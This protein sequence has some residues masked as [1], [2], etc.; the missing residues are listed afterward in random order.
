M[1]IIIRLI[2]ALIG[3]FFLASTVLK[4]IFPSEVAIIGNGILNNIFK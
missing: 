4:L 1:R 2:F 3:I